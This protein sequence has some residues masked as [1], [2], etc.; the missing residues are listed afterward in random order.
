MKDDG[1]SIKTNNLRECRFYWRQLANSSFKLPPE[2]TRAHEY[3]AAINA[4][5]EQHLWNQDERQNYIQ[6]IKQTSRQHLIPQEEL[7]WLNVEQERMCFWIW[8]CCRLLASEDSPLGWVGMNLSLTQPNEPTPYSNLG[9]N[10]HPRTA[11][12]RHRLIIDFLDQSSMPIESKR[13]LLKYWEEQWG[14]TYST[15]RFL[16]LSDQENRQYEWAC[17][18][19]V[20]NDEYAIPHW[21]IPQP[22]TDKEMLD[23]AIAAFDMWQTDISTKKLFIIRMKKAWSQKKHRLAM[24]KKNKKSYNF[25]LTTNTKELLDEMA[26][27]AELSRNEFLERLIKQKH[28]ELNY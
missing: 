15:E 25:T 4:T 14:G 24:K 8:C 5:I 22:T 2:P 20:S 12:E 11:Q 23:A 1:L 7:K 16:W 6:Y 18:Y 13:L 19:V 26:D 3:C 10:M 9:L 21:F 17:N 27:N 28:S